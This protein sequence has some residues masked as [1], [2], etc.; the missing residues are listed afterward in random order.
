[1]VRNLLIAIILLIPGVSMCISDV[2]LLVDDSLSVLVRNI[3]NEYTKQSKSVITADFSDTR[4]VES[5]VDIVISV[6]NGSADTTTFAKDK[7]YL[8]IHKNSN[9]RSSIN[10]NDNLNTILK[11]L[12]KH[13]VLIV[14]SEKSALGS[15]AK[16]ALKKLGIKNRIEIDSI[17]DLVFLAM[18]SGGFFIIPQSFLKY[19]QDIDGIMEIPK[20]FYEQISYN[21]TIVSKNNVEKSKKL[22]SFLMANTQ[23]LE[24]IGFSV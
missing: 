5:T 10:K 14:P 4:A 15:V 21:I 11:L 12:K 20:D 3:I 16:S 1:M 7:L 8:C 18:K 6:N 13:S 2:H 9:L 22:M 17:Q 23:L 24:E 19:Y